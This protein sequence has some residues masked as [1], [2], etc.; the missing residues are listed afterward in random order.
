MK[1]VVFLFPHPTAGPTGGYKV[2]YEYAN[3]LANDGYDV[4]IVYSGSIFWRR[5]SLY[6][7]FT[8]CLRYIQKLFQGYSCRSWFALDERIHEHFTFS[9]NQRHVPKADIYVATSP[10]TAYYLNEYDDSSKKF[11]FIQGYENWGEGL[12]AIL[13]DTYHYPFQKIVIASWLQEML[14]KQ[15]Q[16][17]SIWIPN[18]FDFSKF[19]KT[20]AVEKKN[21]FMVSMLYHQM[22]LKDCAIGFRAFEIVKER[23][24]NLR[25]SLFGVPE[26]PKDLPDWYDYYKRPS[27]E[28]HNRLNNEAAIFIGTSKTEGWGLTVGEAMMCGQAVCCTD[29]AGYQ[30]MAIDGETAL[31]SPVGDSE[32]M[33]NNIIRLIE[34][35][36]LRYRIAND[37]Y[38]F[39]Q[40]FTWEES[41]HKLKTLFE[42]CD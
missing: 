28:L 41:Y 4:H 23:F 15:F 3:R 34:D 21:P 38:Q 9:L 1:R 27:D 33:A 22:E 30:E 35:E 13:H 37:G 36:E 7:K 12:K 32:A 6:H 16:E 5:K 17:E 18:G 42:S 19:R 29:N 31:V 39:I 10:Y 2:V 8:A 25:V 20:I 14:K 24:G 26:R 11:Y 40:R